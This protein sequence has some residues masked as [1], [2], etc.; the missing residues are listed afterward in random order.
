MKYQSKN[1]REKGMQE[2][3]SDV[4]KYDKVISATIIIFTFAKNSFAKVIF[5]RAQLR[6]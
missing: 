5:V 6:H 1:A 4:N 2:F 3:Y